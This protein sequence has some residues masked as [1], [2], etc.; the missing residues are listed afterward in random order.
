MF[1]YSKILGFSIALDIENFVIGASGSDFAQ[2]MHARVSL[3]QNNSI[4]SGYLTTGTNSSVLAGRIA[5][6]LKVEGPTMTFDTGKLKTPLLKIFSQ[7]SCIFRLLFIYR[8]P[9]YRL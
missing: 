8:R 5:H 1:L 9:I 2:M 6:F 7:N 4:L 3:Q